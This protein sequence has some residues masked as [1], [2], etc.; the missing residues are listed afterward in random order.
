M[1]NKLARLTGRSS[2]VYGGIPVNILPKYVTGSDEWRAMS[3]IACKLLHAIILQFNGRMQNNNG[4]L[5]ILMR[6]PE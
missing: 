1:S 5:M 4:R 6:Q 3:P 2:K